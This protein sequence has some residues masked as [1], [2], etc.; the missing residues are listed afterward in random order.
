MLPTQEVAEYERLLSYAPCSHT[1][2]N[3]RSR[4]YPVGAPSN[5]HGFM[6]CGSRL[7]SYFPC[8]RMYRRPFNMRSSSLGGRVSPTTATS[9]FTNSSSSSRDL[10]RP[11]CCFK[12]SQLV[13]KS[14]PVNIAAQ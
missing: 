6:L 3:A 13:G 9:L 4:A 10:I 8:S 14:R 7:H 11:C 2:P 12:S 5:D 1:A